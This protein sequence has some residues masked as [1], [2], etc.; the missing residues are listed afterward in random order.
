M[1]LCSPLF[2][3]AGGPQL[4]MATVCTTGNNL[5][6]EQNMAQSC[7]S[8]AVFPCHNASLSLPIVC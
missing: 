8:G 7:R 4:K 2:W 5:F 3:N 1:S 6:T